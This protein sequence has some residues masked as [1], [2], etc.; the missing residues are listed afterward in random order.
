MLPA[1][2]T[3]SPLA[4]TGSYIMAVKGSPCLFVLSLSVVL[5]RTRMR[6]P[7]GSMGRSTTSSAKAEET[8]KQV[9]PAMNRMMG[10][11]IFLLLIHLEGHFG[12]F[13][14]RLHFLRNR[15]TRNDERHFGPH[16]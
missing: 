5:R 9:K 3:S 14:R 8:A 15:I 12:F 16:G 7:A 6:L 10:L 13:A 11:S 2:R 4:T 1:G